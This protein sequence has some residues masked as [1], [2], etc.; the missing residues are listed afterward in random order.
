[1]V[2]NSAKKDCYYVRFYDNANEITTDFLDNIKAL[3]K[4]IHE[5][6]LK[7]YSKNSVSDSV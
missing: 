3:N 5:D 4:R 6:G 1:M 7:Y 2:T